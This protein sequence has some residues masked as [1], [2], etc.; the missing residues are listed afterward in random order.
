MGRGYSSRT[1]I[2]IFHLELLLPQCTY[3]IKKNYCVHS[4]NQHLI[5]LNS[6]NQYTW[7]TRW[8]TFPWTIMIP[9]CQWRLEI[10]I[11]GRRPVIIWRPRTFH[12]LRRHSG[13]IGHH[14]VCGDRRGQKIPPTTAKRHFKRLRIRKLPQKTTHLKAI[15]HYYQCLQVLSIV[16]SYNCLLYTSPSPRD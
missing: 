8:C 3:P 6:W 11:R 9:S 13:L 15:R 5:L 1:S 4:W 16:I 14:N 12:D 2:V 7:R 10:L